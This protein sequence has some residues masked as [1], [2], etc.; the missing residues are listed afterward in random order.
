VRL[1]TKLREWWHSIPGD[2]RFG[3]AVAGFYFSWLIFCVVIGP[4]LLTLT[5]V[6]IVYP[7]VAI[8][9]L[10][11]LVRLVFVSGRRRRL[12]PLA[13]LGCCLAAIWAAPHFTTLHLTARVYLAG[14][15]NS[16]NDWAQGLIRERQQGLR[17]DDPLRPEEF[18]PGARRF[19]HGFATVVGTIWSDEVRLRIEYG[20]GFYHYGVVVYRSGS[21]PPTQWWQRVIGWPPEVAVYH[22]E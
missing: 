8:A 1:F 2:A 5:S 10:I 9:S 7:L 15:P 13:L 6:I 3:Y 14:G 4:D 12:M 17:G 20:G 18:P 22:E 21:A 11:I 19:L 16:L